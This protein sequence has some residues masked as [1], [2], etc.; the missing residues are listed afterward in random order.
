MNSGPTRLPPDAPVDI[1]HHGHAHLVVLQPPFGPPLLPSRRPTAVAAHD[2]EAARAEVLALDLV[3]AVRREDAPARLGLPGS[4]SVRE[5]LDEVSVAVWGSTVKITDPALV[6]DGLGGA[7][8]DAFEAQRKR[9]PDARIVGV[10]ERDFGASYLKVLAAVPGAPDLVI[11]G[12]SDLEITGDPRATLA[13][14]G[15]DLDESGA[16]YFEDEEDVEDEGVFADYY[17]FLHT[18]T[19]GA[20][21]VYSREER[22]ESTFLVERTAEGENCIDAVWFSG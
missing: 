18:L 8:D 3:A 15:V 7:L 1:R 2:P 6:E 12:W 21:S 10:C 5:H 9:F 14:L 20:L 22:Q 17:A 13:H 16:E 4:P 19:D 11:E